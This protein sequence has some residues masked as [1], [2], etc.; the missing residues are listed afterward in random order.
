M[1]TRRDK[2]NSPMRNRVTPTALPLASGGL[3]ATVDNPPT[4]GREEACRPEPRRGRFRARR[5][6]LR[7]S[8]AAGRYSAAA[9]AEMHGRRSSAHG[10]LCGGLS[11]PLER[12]VVCRCATCSNPG[13][14]RPRSGEPPPTARLTS[15]THRATP[16][17]SSTRVLRKT[18]N[19]LGN[20]AAP[21]YIYLLEDFA[22]A[23]F[24]D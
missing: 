18:D 7:G 5:R 13:V 17:Q 24:N 8:A 1:N 3:I 19:S 12:W 20:R 10:K 2:V 23:G 11:H 9:L 4:R 15:T 21:M 6:G 22:W 16:V 14:S